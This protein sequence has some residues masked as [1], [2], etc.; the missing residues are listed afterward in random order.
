MPKRRSSASKS[1]APQLL[2]ALA[3]IAALVFLAGELFAFL[4]SDL[5]RVLAYRHLHVGDRAQ[6]VRIIGKRVHEGF[7]AARVGRER[8]HEEIVAGGAGGVPRWTADLPPDGSPLQVNYAIARAVE[9]GG[10]NVLSGREDAGPDGAL[11]VTLQVGVPGRP[12]HELVIERPARASE[13]EREAAPA[14]VALV[15]YGLSEDATLAAQVLAR[16]EPFAVAVPAAGEDHEALQRNAR[17]SGHERLLQIPMEPEN[18]PRVN[19]GPG[20]LLVSMPAR[21]I[22]SLTREY[23]ADA[24]DVVAVSNLMGSF[25]TQDEPFMDAFYRELKRAGV[26][27]LHVAPAPRSVCRT[28][29]ARTGIAYDEPDELLDRETRGSGPKELE[30]SWRATLEYA[31]KHGR[32]IVMLRVTPLSA[33]WLDRALEPRALEGVTL[34]PLSGVLHHAGAH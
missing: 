6:I 24:G 25:A 5:G 17:A 19:P 12:T 11:T 33:R 20:T 1:R 28:L 29:A 31:R 30:R 15:L 13:A 26:T 8:L 3:A 23:L 2:G 27:F 16:H 7:A 21:R 22:A 32:A 14:R 9:K 18:Y 34:V 10:A 4:T